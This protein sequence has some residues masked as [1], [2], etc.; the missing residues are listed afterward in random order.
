MDVVRATLAHSD[1]KRLLALSGFFFNERICFKAVR[2]LNHTSR[3]HGKVFISSIK[4]DVDAEKS[5]R[6]RFS[7]IVE[8]FMLLNHG[9]ASKTSIDLRVKTSPS[10]RRV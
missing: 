7:T 2:L 10:N 5:S 4:F 3:P 6:V 1:T 8:D 9:R